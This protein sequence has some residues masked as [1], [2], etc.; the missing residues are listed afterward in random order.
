MLTYPGDTSATFHSHK[1]RANYRDPTSSKALKTP[2]RT[3]INEP[4][5][6]SSKPHLIY[7][8]MCAN[9][10]LDYY[11]HKNGTRFELVE[12]ETL[13]SYPFADS[14][15]SWI[16]CCFN[17]KEDSSINNFFSELQYVYPLGPAVTTCK[18]LIQ[19]ETQVGCGNCKSVTHPIVGYRGRSLG[20]INHASYEMSDDHEVGCGSGWVQQSKS[21]LG[22]GQSTSMVTG[23]VPF[24]GGS[25]GGGWV[26]VK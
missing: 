24:G 15:G 18:I 10:A 17:A 5:Q 8:K 2:A 23:D 21:I 25:G 19:G 14:S 6:A 1:R 22:L 16:H 3:P 11:N 20:N 4:E 12:D 13:D 7:K 9:I 26:V